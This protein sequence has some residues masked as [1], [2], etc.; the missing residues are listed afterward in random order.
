MYIR[1]E[2]NR[3]LD[4]LA[5]REA[6][7]GTR[8]LAE[9]FTES[10]IL[11][12]TLPPS[13]ALGIYMY[14]VRECAR[15]RWNYYPAYPDEEC[16]SKNFQTPAYFSP[17]LPG[18]LN[19]SRLHTNIMPEAGHFSRSNAPR[20][21]ASAVK[22][23]CRFYDDCGYLGRIIMINKNNFIGHVYRRFRI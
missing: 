4:T 10:L 16:R 15:D 6:F 11:E 22:N 19:F 7:P 18:L 2:L 21:C 13:V 3:P 1:E 14:N 20:R 9:N 23:D 8:N 17:P 12:E 5:D